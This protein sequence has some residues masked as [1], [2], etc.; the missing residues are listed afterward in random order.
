MN[1]T[2]PASAPL[3]AYTFSV[4]TLGGTATSG[5]V[6]VT[7]TPAQSSSAVAKGSVFRHG[8]STG[9]SSSVTM[10]S[11]LLD[12]PHTGPS[13]GVAKGSVLLP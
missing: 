7:V 4:D 10:G 2:V 6:T 5:A 8:P 1:V 13:F 9:S 12:G 3:Q 11:V